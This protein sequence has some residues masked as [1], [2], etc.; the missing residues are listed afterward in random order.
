MN[1]IAETSVIVVS[2]QRHDHLRTCLRALVDQN[3]AQIVVVAD[4]PAEAVMPRN[5]GP[6]RMV[7]RP[8]SDWNISQARNIGLAAAQTKFVAFID[9][10][11]V[12]CDGWLAALVAP[13]GSGE[14]DAA[15]GYV[16]LRSS[17][18]WQFRGEKIDCHAVVT[19]LEIQGDAPVIFE[20]PHNG[21]ILTIGTNCAFHA[22]SVAAVGGFDPIFRYF[23]DESDLNMRLS[24]NQATTAIVPLAVVRHYLAPGA[25]RRSDGCLYDLTEIGASVSAFIQRHA[26]PHQ[27]A[28]ALAAALEQ[29]RCG[30]LRAMIRGDL[31]PRDVRRGERQLR[32]GAGFADARRRMRKPT[33]EN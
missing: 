18:R 23:L 11:A 5:T 15:T 29:Q 1:A 9:D 3:P 20:A 12:P 25:Y 14:A 4:P 7:F 8:F 31:E 13:L 26:P 19:P 2:N 21:A 33:S 28:T 24:K 30:L 27:R 22:E 10:D 17:D 6:V 32:F 16:R